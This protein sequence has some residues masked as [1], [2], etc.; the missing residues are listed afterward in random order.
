M[1]STK[2]FLREYGGSGH[3]QPPVVLLHGLF[4]S[5]T[6]WHSIARRLA[7]SR[8]V[9]APDL[10]NHGRSTSCA[11]MTYPAMAEDLLALLDDQGI[12][13]AVLVGHSM[14][15]KAAMWL[16]LNW[17][18]RVHALAVADIAPVTYKHRFDD[19]LNALAALD[20][21]GLRDRRDAD[22]QLARRLE[23]PG[24]RGYLLQSLEKEGNGWRWRID[25]P[26]L[27]ASMQDLLGF[28]DTT[29]RQYPGP[30]FFIYGAQS[31]YVTGEY[32]PAIR[33]RFPLARLRSV[34][35]AGH[36]VYA[37]QPETFLRALQ[38][39]LTAKAISVK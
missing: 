28:P 36:W 35:G 7:E 9:L 17:P 5:S 23:N 12:G 1:S 31:D 4:G 29:G 6:N 21:E 8:R 19:V 32:L 38:G 2:L 3:G 20:L 25:L 37:D 22:E 15:G 39:F 24:L 18:E 27:G 14:G 11:P 34:P 13:Q 33:E 16:A 30:A 26:L 10:R